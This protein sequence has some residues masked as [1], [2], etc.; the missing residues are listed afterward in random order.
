MR[1]D[2]ET[3]WSMH[4]HSPGIPSRKQLLPSQEA[5]ELEKIF[6]EDARVV[7]VR[8][9]ELACL[10]P[11]AFICRSPQKRNG[12]VS[13]GMMLYPGTQQVRRQFDVVLQSIRPVSIAEGLLQRTWPHSQAQRSLRKR[14]GILVPVKNVLV[15]R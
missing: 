9:G 11:D 14:K 7:T 12:L 4:L 15:A 13:P 10:S 1:D 8:R 5:A 6:K 2:P 3:K